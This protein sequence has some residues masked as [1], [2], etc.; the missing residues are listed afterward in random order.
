MRAR[1][2]GENEWGKEHLRSRASWRL[3]WR[4]VPEPDDN[5]CTEKNETTTTSRGVSPSQTRARAHTRMRH[6]T[7]LPPRTHLA[8]GARG[9]GRAGGGPRGGARGRAGGRAGA[10]ARGFLAGGRGAG[11]VRGLAVPLVAARAPVRLGRGRAVLAGRGGG[12]DAAEEEGAGVWGEHRIESE[13]MGIEGHQKK[14]VRNG[15][16]AVWLEARAGQKRIVW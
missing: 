16:K 9:R 12:N 15:G 10:R 11:A 3:S 1:R 14:R 8:V 6:H 2:A 4:L 13:R 5:T 7:T